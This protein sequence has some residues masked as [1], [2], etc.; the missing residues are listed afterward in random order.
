[1][2]A[3]AKSLSAA[4]TKPASGPVPAPAE[5]AR[6]FMRLAGEEDE[7]RLYGRIGAD[8]RV[9]PRRDVSLRVTGRRLDHSIDARREPFLNFQMKDVSVGGL[10]ATSQMPLKIGE[11]VAVFFPPEGTSRGWDA[12]GRVVRVQSQK[13]GWSVAVG[14]DAMP[15]A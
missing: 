1:M 12:Y 9:F 11:R 4:L 7:P 5:P 14:F 13:S 8:R 2:V 15:A 10:A 6:P 3:L